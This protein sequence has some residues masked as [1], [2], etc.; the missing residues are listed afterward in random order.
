VLEL[1]GQTASGQ[2]VSTD[3]IDAAARAYIRAL[4]TAARLVTLAAESPG[5]QQADLATTP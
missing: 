2:G 5:L 4:S 1:N 3:I